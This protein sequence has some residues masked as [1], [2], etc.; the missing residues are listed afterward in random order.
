MN[1]PLLLVALALPLAAEARQPARPAPAAPGIVSA[2]DVRAAQAGVEILKAGG[3]AIDAAIATMLAL[4]VVEPQSSGLGGGSFWV[5]HTRSGKL[6]TIDA[7]ETA[8]AAA[9][10]RWFFGPD[11]KVISKRD[12]VPGGKSVGVPGAIRGMAMAWRQ[13]GRLPWARLFAPAVRLA[14]QGWTASPRFAA[15]LTSYGRHL[16]PETRALYAGPNGEPLKAG[17]RLT[18]P[19]QAALLER[20]ARLGADSFYVGPQ[21]QKVVATVNGAARNPSR[22]TAGD[23][24]SYAAKPRPPVCATYRLH[25]ICS[26]GPPSSGGLTVLMILKQLERFDMAALGK[27]SPV[28]WHLFAQ[29]SRLAY[30]DRDLYIGDP[31]FV[32]VP[33]AGLLDAGYLAG[34]S[35]LISPDRSIAS[36]A[37]GTPPGAPQRQRAAPAEVAGTTSLAVADGRGGV[38]HVT[39]TVEGVFGSGLSVDGAI[40]NNELTD[41]DLPPEKNGFLVA[42]RVEGGKRPRSSMSPTILYNPD[43]SVRLS[44]GAAGGPTI[45]AQIAKALVGVLD[46]QL[47]AQDAIA[48]GLIFAPGETALPSRARSSTRWC[49]RCARWA[50]R[51]SAR[52]WGLK[53]N[54]VER[55]GGRWVG[56]ADPRS[57]GR[58]GRHAAGR[59]TAPAR[60]APKPNQPPE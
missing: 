53:A 18:N 52:R 34:R 44:I 59:V 27:D 17:D 20:L 29:S 33:T 23:L 5:T 54:A 7:R 13:G 43:G 41:F 60:I 50:T 57:E 14:R 28:A 4:G 2:A 30:A 32:Q 42:N 10:P 21:A 45:I 46:W 49:R 31:D 15:G 19:A 22:M 40:L 24:A 3:S 25:R 47:P 8:P 37:A 38:V 48:M 9:D 58:V 11:G 35:A 12:A 36:V 1:M 55:V 51:S 56:A 26:M 39:T 16:S 6:A